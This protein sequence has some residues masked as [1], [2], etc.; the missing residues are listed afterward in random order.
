MRA[1]LSD[2]AHRF[3]LL[4][5]PGFL[6]LCTQRVQLPANLCG[7]PALSAEP[8]V[9]EREPSLP[10]VR[11]ARGGVR[12]A[13]GEESKVQWVNAQSLGQLLVL[14]SRPVGLTLLSTAAA[15]AAGLF[16]SFFAR[17]ALTNAVLIAIAPLA[18]AVLGLRDGGIDLGAEAAVD[19]R[20]HLVARRAGDDEPCP[21]LGPDRGVGVTHLAE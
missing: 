5:K 6:I 3:S 7:V 16:L 11:R 18:R 20:L 15:S 9:S 10:L 17:L 4:V 8:D 21:A 19:V 13:G 14:S 12:G 1:L 2:R